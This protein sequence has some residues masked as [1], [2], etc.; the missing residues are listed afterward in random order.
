MLAPGFADPV[1]EAQATFR[2]AMD[3]LA[4]PGRT[5]RVKG[6]A[7][8]PEPLSPVAAALLLTLADHETTVHLDAVLAATPSVAAWLRFHTGTRIA[9]APA[10]A[11]FAVLTG[12]ETLADLSAYAVGTDAYPDRS[13]TLV[14]QVPHLG[15]GRTHVLNGPGIRGEARLVADLPAGFVDAWAA[16]RAL[17]PRGV[18][19]F[20]CGPGHV[21]GLP[22]S[23]A[24]REV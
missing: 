23:V 22:R 8:A 9:P 21:V 14:V 6:V 12:P 11:T 13:T 7:A 24:I 10:A 17:F 20:L 15:K 19:V 3:A 1:F 16:N 5:E 2:A 18:D 4:R